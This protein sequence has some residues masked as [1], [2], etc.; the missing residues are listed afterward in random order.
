MCTASLWRPNNHMGP[1]GGAEGGRAVNHQIVRVRRFVTC[2]H[3]GNMNGMACGYAAARVKA[4]PK[5]TK[6][7]LQH[8]VWYL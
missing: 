7:H 2:A 8:I 3:T 4:W 5:T 1:G 6:G